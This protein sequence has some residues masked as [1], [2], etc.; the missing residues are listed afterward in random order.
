[1]LFR[2]FIPVPITRKLLTRIFS[3]IRVSTTSFYK[4]VPCWEWT[5]YVD[6]RS[7]YGRLGWRGAK[8]MF[9][10]RVIYSQFVEPIPPHLESDHLCRVRHCVNPVHIEPVTKQINQLRG[11][12]VAAQ[13]A[14]RQT[15]KRGHQFVQEANRRTCKECV[16]INSKIWRDSLPK[17]HPSKIKI[18]E[19]ARRYVAKFP[20]DHP[21]WD[22]VRRKA[23]EYYYRK[24]NE[25]MGSK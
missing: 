8:N 17:D 9:A 7:G 21:H 23:R 20:I 6:K 24:K 13:S 5:A 4:G 2:E 11:V 19:A 12:G 10:H 18:R 15:C 22:D 14:A 16:R 3:K 1:M 25:K